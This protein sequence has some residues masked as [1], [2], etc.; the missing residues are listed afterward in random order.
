MF[1]HP[2]VAEVIET[3]ATDST[4]AYRS[5]QVWP[6]CF[7]TRFNVDAIRRYEKAEIKKTADSNPDLD[8]R[9]KTA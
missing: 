9:P 8:A 3:F 5:S 6:P 1:Q 2:V 7:G 4:G